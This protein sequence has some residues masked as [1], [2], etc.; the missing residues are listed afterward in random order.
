SLAENRPAGR[1]VA[2]QPVAVL[3]T[4]LGGLPMGRA[5]RPYYAW[6]GD[7]T[8][9]PHFWRVLKL[10]RFTIDVMFFPPVTIGDFADRKALALHCRDIIAGG[11]EQ[12]LTGRLDPASLAL[13]SSPEKKQLASS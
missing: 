5:G 3:C 7:M 9:V 6:F 2:V 11:V 12:C 8:F 4:E 13:P 10:G 1:P